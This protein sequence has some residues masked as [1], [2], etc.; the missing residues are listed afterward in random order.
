MN[1]NSSIFTS[2]KAM[3]EN[4]TFGVR[5]IKND[6]TLKKSHFLFLL[7]FKIGIISV[8]SNVSA[9]RTE[10]KLFSMLFLMLLV[11]FLGMILVVHIVC[12]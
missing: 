5:E 3:S 4:I 10:T 2:G 11:C 7:R 9:F 6:L 8:Y 1:T 12:N